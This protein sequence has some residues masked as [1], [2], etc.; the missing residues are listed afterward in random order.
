VR[1]VIARCQVD[2]A[3]RLTAHLPMAN[4]LLLVKSDGSVSVHSDDRA[5]KPLNWMSPPC[6]LT[7]AP[8]TWT[9]ANKAGEKLVITLE[10]VLHDSAH[11]LGAEPGLQKDGVE[12]HLQELLAEH[13]TTLGDGY[14]LIRREYMTAIGPVD[15]LCRD[16]VGVTVAVEIKR[17]GE[18]DGVEQ[19][20]RYLELLN[21]DPLLAPVQGV[22]A[23]QLIKP[24]A[25]TLAEDRGIRCV[26]LDYDTLRGIESSEFRLF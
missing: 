11:E 17:R 24:Q 3:G 26:T 5:Y 21:R 10:E 16:H 19:L 8:G 14:S 7:E 2:Y 12:A 9:V 22:F 4:R 23:A 18:I 1:L 20:T 25:R 15:I 6:W 13:I